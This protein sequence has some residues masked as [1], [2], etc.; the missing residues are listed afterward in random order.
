MG[1]SRLTQVNFLSN[2]LLSLLL[3]PLLQMSSKDLYA[4]TACSPKPHHYP[5]ITWV[6]SLAQA[7]TSLSRRPLAP[8]TRILPHF[9][10]RSNYSRIHRYADTKLFVALFVREMTKH[11]PS[12]LQADPYEKSPE[13][14]VVVVNNLCP[15]T[16]DT[17]ADDN[18][19]FWLRIPMNLNRKLR[20]RT[21]QEGSRTLIYAAEVAG[22]ESHGK[23]IASN[24]ISP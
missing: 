12:P 18:L 16:V 11:V 19:P 10:Q 6:G 13:E 20:A 15:G 9:S 8:S 4:A 21:V 23:Y 2:A 14:G 7:F 17:A 3:L 22:S 24:E 5:V 1:K